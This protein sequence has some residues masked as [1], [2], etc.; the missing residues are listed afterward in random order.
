MIEFDMSMW[1]AFFVVVV[2]LLVFA[3][4]TLWL[5]ERGSNGG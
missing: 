4:V 5:F 2:P 3:A 1:D